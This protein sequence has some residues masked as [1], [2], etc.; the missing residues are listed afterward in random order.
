MPEYTFESP[1]E[2]LR[3]LY[4]GEDSPDGICRAPS[5]LFG[6]YSRAKKVYDS[7]LCEPCKQGITRENMEREY[8]AI[9]QYTPEE[10]IN[11]VLAV[12]GNFILKLNGVVLGKV[13]CREQE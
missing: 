6:W 11:A 1:L 12:G 13:E 10:Q 8:A 5:T 3:H 7:S 2:L 4:A 9:L